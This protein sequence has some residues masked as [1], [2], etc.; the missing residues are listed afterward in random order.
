MA[1]KRTTKRETKRISLKRPG[2]KGA[3]NSWKSR[4]LPAKERRSFNLP[5]IRAGALLPKVFIALSAMIII[6]SI[7]FGLIYTYRYVTVT[8]YFQINSIEIEGNTR[9]SSKNILDLIETYEGMNSFSLSI[10]KI[11]RRLQLNPWVQGASVTRIIPDTL[12]I[13]VEE[14]APVYWVLEESTLWYTD[15][16]GVKI[17]P[18]E[19][20]LLCTLPTLSVDKGAADLTSSLPELMQSIQ[21]ANLPVDITTISDIG[22]SAARTLEFFISG[23]NLRITIGLDSWMQNLI[24][25][26]ETLEDLSMRGELPS[27]RIVKATG[28]N[29][30]VETAKPL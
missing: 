22:L 27:V 19:T 17:A 11:E 14:K 21:E 25:T 15:D 6:G 5:K 10:A 7:S 16:T 2:S 28:H 26:K 12:I 23:A 18:V 30:W 1:I 4:P 8:P 3:S 9:L 13:K 24:R 20:G 29:V